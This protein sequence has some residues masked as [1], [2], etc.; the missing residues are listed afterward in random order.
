MLFTAAFTVLAAYGSSYA[1]TQEE[2]SPELENG[3]GDV[4]IVCNPPTTNT[5]MQK[6][7][8]GVVIWSSKGVAT[9]DMP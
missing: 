5:C 9:I 1:K 7:V 2:V 4:S 3:G 8:L 6:K